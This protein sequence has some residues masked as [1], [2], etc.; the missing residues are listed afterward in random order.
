MRD[1]KKYH[2]FYGGT[3]SNWYPAKFLDCNGV[4]FNCSEQYMMY[5]KAKL[6][7]DKEIADKIMKAIH[8]AEQK[9]LGKQ[10]RNFDKD[11]W[12]VFARTFV[13]TGCY[14]KFTQ[15]KD[16]FDSLMETRG[17]LLVEA[18]PSDTIWGIG[19]S[20]TDKKRFDKN[21]WKGTNWLGEVLTILRESF[22]N[23]Y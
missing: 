6:F 20:E 10:V 14:Y 2:F 19:L 7:E 5:Q 21:Q 4:E 18:S 13:L 1:Y 15:N 23:K 9:A 8:P 22:E 12:Q 17:K 11:Y 3:F 16:L